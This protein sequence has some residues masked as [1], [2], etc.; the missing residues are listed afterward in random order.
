M[1]RYE[2]KAPPVAVTVCS[3]VTDVEKFIQHA[4]AE[5]DARLHHPVQI[6]AG[7][8]VFP[9]LSKLADCGLDLRLDWPAERIIENPPE[10]EPSKPSK[11]PA[12]PESNADITDAEVPF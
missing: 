8:S 9:L 12:A 5:L 3:V 11:L 2:P 4:L 10:M 1:V 6:K 7:D